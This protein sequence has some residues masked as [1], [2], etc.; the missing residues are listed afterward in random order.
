MQ[1]FSKEFE[2]FKTEIKK[3]LGSEKYDQIADYI[4]HLHEIIITNLQFNGDSFGT[5]LF[6]QRKNL[7]MFMDLSSVGICILNPEKYFYVNKTWCDLTGYSQNESKQITPMDILHPDMRDFVMK[8][9]KE[10]LDGK[11][12]P[13]RYNIKLLTKE[14]IEKWVDISFAVISYEGQP[15]TLA[16]MNDITKELETKNA[17]KKSEE[18]FKKLLN[19]SPVGI[20]IQRKNKYFYVNRA[21]AQITGYRIKDIDKVGPFDIIHPEMIEFASSLNYQKIKGD[22]PGT[23]YNLKILTKDKQE[24]WL[25]LS[26][27]PIF[28]ENQYANIVVFTDITDYYRS[29]EALIASEKKYRSLIE[30]LRHEFVFFRMNTEGYMEY[31]SSSIKDILGYDPDDYNVHYKKN[32][33]DN[34]INEE[35]IQKTELSIAGILQFPFEIEYFD[36]QKNRH[37]LEVSETPIIDNEGNVISV[38]GIVRDITSQKLAEERLKKSENQLRILNAQKDK[39]FSLLAHDLRGPIG[40]FLQISELLKIKYESL[41]SDQMAVFFENLHEI[42]GRTYKLLDN[43][44]IW[45]RSQLGKLEIKIEKIELYKLVHEV[46][47][48]FEES[49]K[50]KQLTFINNISPDLIVSVDVNILEALFRNIISNAVKFSYQGGKIKVDNNTEFDKASNKTYHIVS[51]TDNG[52]G[53]PEDKIDKIFNF[54][55]HY[56][57]V[58]T[59]NEKGTGLGLNLCKEL[60]EKTGEKIWLASEE[61]K[62]TTFYFTLKS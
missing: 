30:N 2:K 59:S 62:G 52:V 29:R 49:L 7:Q 17:L 35:A 33:T 44:L 3:K 54:E 12:V 58:G 8:R 16:I 31:V 11:D 36:I 34:P 53:I 9:A 51:I 55:D 23:K 19:L 28:Y 27:A 41:S 50:S 43:V 24:K 22:R 5:N 32:L 15:A 38:E 48:L 10:R 25:E 13:Q 21:W 61:G 26:I 45:S 1:K 56:S 60:I 14:N 18:Q 37:V 20:S 40:N 47:S 39:F 57:T 6:E 42:A 4:N 46:V